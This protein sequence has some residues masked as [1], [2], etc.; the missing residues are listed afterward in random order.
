MFDGVCMPPIITHTVQE[1]G[2]VYQRKELVH[3]LEFTKEHHDLANTEVCTFIITK[4]G[5]NVAD[6][7]HS[8]CADVPRQNRRD[9]YML[10]N[11]IAIAHKTSDHDAAGA[12]VH[13]AARHCVGFPHRLQHLRQ[14]PQACTT[15]KQN[16]CSISIYY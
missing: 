10:K 11:I 5:I 16:T 7:H 1:I 6:G 4:T 9:G 12:C 2:Y 8:G 3:L 15:F 14:R 13:V